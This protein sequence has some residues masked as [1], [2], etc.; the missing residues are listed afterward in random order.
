M[1]AVDAYTSSVATQ[2]YIDD[3]CPTDPLQ[4]FE[5]ECLCS[6]STAF[7]DTDNFD[8]DNGLLVQDS[9][10]TDIKERRPHSANAFE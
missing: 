7:T 3:L 4:Q 9:A 2:F 6:F 1:P 5:E 10:Q 8:V